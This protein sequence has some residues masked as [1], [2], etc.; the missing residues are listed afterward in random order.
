MKME[1]VD[2]NKIIITVSFSDLKQ[3]NIDMSALTYSTAEAQ[4]LFWDMMEQAE[5]E[6]GFDTSS[7]Q[8]C[9]EAYPST[10]DEFIITITKVPEM[11]D[12][13]SI[14][15]YIKNRYSR[16][17]LRTRKKSKRLSMSVLIYSFSDIDAVCMMAKKLV[18]IYSGE[19]NLYK[20]K[21]TYYLEFCKNSFTIIDFRDIE[22]VLSEYGDRVTNVSF[23]GGYLNEHGKKIINTDA[24][25][26]LNQYF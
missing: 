2:N 19:S 13:E 11:D 24:I 15:K 9:I 16:K 10:S 22:P 3:R 6:F 23:Y 25:E 5:T 4:E 14:Q 7:A 1:K 18:D 26:T 12:F 17:E 8:L 21:E 20:L